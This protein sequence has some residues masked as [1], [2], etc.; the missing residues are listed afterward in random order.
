MNT[1]E[2]IIE[3][4]QEDQHGVPVTS[5]YIDGRNIIE[6]L[7][8]YERPFAE[9]EGAP[10][11]AGAYEGLSP[12]ILLDNFMAS[13]HEDK[14]TIV[15][16]PC[17]VPGCWPL[18]VTVQEVEGDIIWTDFEQLHRGEDSHEYWDYRHFGSFVF[19][20]N[21]YIHEMQKLRV[22]SNDT[23]HQQG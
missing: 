7:A 1:F 23:E 19:D 21:K 4:K 3:T 5:I 8:E 13:S 6:M 14:L 18:M 20:K 10:E 9:Q 22:V 16:C 15:D 17:N 2:L 12:A 11:I